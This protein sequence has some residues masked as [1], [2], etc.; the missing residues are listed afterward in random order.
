[1][2][3]VGQ[4][5]D[6]RMSSEIQRRIDQLGEELQRSVVVND[7]D[8]Q[9]IY[10][11]QHYGDEDEVRIR[12][13]LH[14]DAGSQALAH[15]FELGVTRWTKAGRVPPA[16]EI[17]M[18]ERFVAPLRWHGELLGFVFVIDA[19]GTLTAD[20]TR[21]IEEFA[22]EAARLI[23]AARHDADQ[24]AM[25]ESRDIAAWLDGTVEGRRQGQVALVARGLLP[26][27][28]HVRVVAVEVGPA[29]RPET[30]QA[31]VNLALRH[32]FRSVAGRTRGTVLSTVHCGRGEAALVWPDKVDRERAGRFA[33]AVMSEIRD[34]VG[35]DSDIQ[36]GIGSAV[37]SVDSAW[38]SSREAQLA[39]KAVPIV[40]DETVVW[41]ENLGPLQILL[42]IPADELDDTVIPQ[43]VRV[44]LKADTH[45]TLVET[46][47]MYLR[48]GGSSSATAAALNLHRT[49]VYYRLDR[50]R[51]VA[52]VD[53]DDGETR[54][55][56]HLGLYVLRML[57]RDLNP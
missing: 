16:P 35:P 52:G 24:R 6:A 50:I 20:E 34:V 10:S 39:A 54:L 12:G 9:L 3:D 31:R 17:G 40:G 21:Q 15:L 14:R 22:H 25:A 32:A 23:V 36:V 43:A 7:P 27:L 28:P 4:Q 48:K 1:M 55:L 41:W 13:V 8:M 33:A 37:T 49:T 26:D 18:A 53:I 57:Q 5:Y 11:S 45:G 30:D 47:D 44:L 19:D 46:L 2:L 38:V 56:L 51:E 29:G 42:R